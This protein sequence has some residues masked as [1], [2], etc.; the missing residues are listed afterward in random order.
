M[1]LPERAVF[2]LTR[3]VL[4]TRTSRNLFAMYCVGLHM[5]VFLMLYWMGTS[6]VE[7]HASNLGAATVAAGAGAAGGAGSKHGDWAQ[8][9]FDGASG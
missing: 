7:K 2:Q 4:A 3:M 6:D 9:G 8:D 5:L 1:S